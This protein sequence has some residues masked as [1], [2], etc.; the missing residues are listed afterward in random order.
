MAIQ[1]RVTPKTY[2]VVCDANKTV[3]FATKKRDHFIKDTYF[4]SVI[5]LHASNIAENFTRFFRKRHKTQPRKRLET[6]NL[7]YD[8]FLDNLIFITTCVRDISCRKIELI[9]F[10][11]FI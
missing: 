4:I 10:Y 6:Y 3:F 5:I 1:E 11:F 8:S 7:T 2:R 9:Y